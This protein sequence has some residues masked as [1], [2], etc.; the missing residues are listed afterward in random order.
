MAGDPVSRAGWLTENLPIT[1]ALTWVADAD[2]RAATVAFL[3]AAVLIGVAGTLFV[4]PRR[5]DN[6]R[7]SH[8]Q[9]GRSRRPRWPGSPC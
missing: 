5:L 3:W 4:R 6:P 7:A 9:T 8:Y 1:N 2:A